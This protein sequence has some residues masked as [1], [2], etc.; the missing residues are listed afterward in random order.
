MIWGWNE[1][2]IMNY[3]YLIQYNS[4]QERTITPFAG[5]LQIKSFYVT[6]QFGNLSILLI[7]GFTHQPHLCRHVLQHF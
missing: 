7:D 5:I 3:S 4:K 1:L 6:V 2:I